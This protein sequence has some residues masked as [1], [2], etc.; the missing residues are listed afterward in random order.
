MEDI[1][2][3]DSDDFW[4]SMA[5]F[6]FSESSWQNAPVQVDQL[7]SLLQLSPENR[8]LD[9]PCGPGRHTL[10]FT[11]RGFSVT[12]VDRTQVYLDEARS[13]A[14]AEG[15]APELLLADM[16]H[17]RRPDTYD[18]VLSLFTSFGYFDDPAEN[19]RVLS[20]YYDSLRAGG[21]LLMEMAGKEVIARI[22]QQRDW[23]EHEGVYLLEERNV[24]ADWR[25]MDGRWVL[26]E[27][28]LIT[29]RCFNHWIYSAGEL[30]QLLAGSGFER[31]EF[32]GDLENAPY[33]QAASR[34]VAVAH[35]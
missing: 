5:P 32:Y 11:R 28:G 9:C 14:E 20:N 35:K 30:T 26:V 33:D 29:E 17:F 8:V 3:H 31:I 1:P 2:W 25:Q 23:R 7:I 24:T 22:Y 15:L 27:D 19:E 6:M 13:R 4:R 12:G 16:R 10:E 21:V 18:V 34:L